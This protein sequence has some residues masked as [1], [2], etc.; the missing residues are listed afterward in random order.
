MKSILLFALLFVYTAFADFD[1]HK[2]NIVDSKGKVRGSRGLRDL[3][4]CGT[5]IGPAVISE[6]PTLSTEML[7]YD[8]TSLTRFARKKK[9]SNQARMQDIADT[10]V[11]AEVKTLI[12]QGPV[13]NRIDLTIV[14]DGYTEAEKQKFFEDA[15]KLTDDLFGQDTFVTYRALF[16][17]HAVYVP[18]RE[19][20]IGDGEPK[21]TAIGLY[22]DSMARQAVVCGNESAAR[23]A[24]R[25]APDVDF[26]ILLGND[27]FYGGL[28]GEFAITTSAP[29][30]I[31]TVLRHELGHNFGEVGEE[32]DGGQ[33]YSGANFSRTQD[34]SWKHH[35]RGNAAEVYRMDL[36]S[37]KA[38]WRDLTNGDYEQ[39]FST[40]K[41][42]RVLFD[43]SSLGFDAK[44]DV[45]VF[46]DNVALPYDGSYN[47]D[48]N[49]Y[50]VEKRLAAGQHS[51]RF[52]R[53]ATD[54]NNIVSKV[55]I[56]TLPES[57]PLGT[58]TIGAFAT[59]NQSGSMVGYRP[60]ERTCLMK[61]MASHHF[62]DVCLENMWRNFLRQISL[63]DSVTVVNK[64]VELAVVPVGLQRLKIEWLDARG[65]LRVDL[66]N[67]LKWTA[68]SGDTGA[69]T[70]RVSFVSDE[71]KD[72]AQNSYTVHTK[73]F[74]L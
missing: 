35:L 74:N 13:E 45:E 26:P 37:Y 31:T 69:W 24:A 33:V 73:A 6:S 9:F 17:V 63:I 20:G 15:Q 59:Y 42:G 22:R 11:G 19:S 27:V 5:E 32:Y 40:S 46:V 2:V 70:V 43:F 8:C 38:P 57:F 18:S 71:I 14:G 55:A 44:T 10:W 3:S 72:P 68:A 16:N 58:P 21:N 64:T 61:D 47:Y 52:H 41:E 67:Q 34:V 48:R 25:M 4:L 12:H 54:R 65:N 50:L 56:Y 30:N 51:I 60:T 1:V 66:T 36:I 39:A 23:R 29:L 28:G 62:C 53:V 49:F 7:R